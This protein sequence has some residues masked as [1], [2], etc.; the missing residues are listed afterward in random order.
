MFGVL[1]V[2]NLFDARSEVERLHIQVFGGHEKSSNS[3]KLEVLVS[4]VVT[5]FFVVLIHEIDSLIDHSSI[6]ESH[7]DHHFKKPIYDRSSKL[8]RYL[9]L[10]G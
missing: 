10:S 4:L 2:A 1:V 6:I 7:D 9:S 5:T 8:S 3:C